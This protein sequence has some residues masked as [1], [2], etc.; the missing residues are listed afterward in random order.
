MTETAY[1]NFPEKILFCIGNPSLMEL[2][3][4]LGNELIDALPVNFQ[5]ITWPGYLDDLRL[6]LE[7]KHRDLLEK[8]NLPPVFF[9]DHV[10]SSM[11]QNPEG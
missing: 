10:P 11:N 2:Q 7:E 8:S 5:K 3:M 6:T 4:F 1:S 9:I